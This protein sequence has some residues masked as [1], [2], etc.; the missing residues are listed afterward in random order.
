MPT[1]SDRHKAVDHESGKAFARIRERLAKTRSLLA[2]H[3]AGVLG[4]GAR[5]DA[6]ALE[7]LEDSLLLADVG[8]ETARVVVERVDE[9]ARREGEDVRGALRAA[10][11]EILAPCAQE[12][13]IRP[14]PRP[15]VIMTVGVNGVGKTTTIGK[16]AHRLGGQGLSVVLAAGDTFRAAA[17]EQLKV[18]GERIGAPVIAQPTGADAASVAHDAM[19]AAAARRADVLIV[20]TAGRQHTHHNLME[21]LR[22][23]KRVIARIDPDAPHEVL[24]VLDAGT[25]QNALSQLRHFDQTV[26]VS[27]LCLTKLDGTAKGGILL[28]LAHAHGIPIRFIGIGEQAGDLRAFRAEEFVDAMLPDPRVD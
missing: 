14:G 9:L 23:I 15:F 10:L 16:L 8:I 19:Q 25:G 4:R 26:S 3:L 7:E 11:L 6:A 28:A 5:L 22:K 21:E 2:S 18:W 12:L 24:M 1:A 27:G 17:V 13:V 20:D